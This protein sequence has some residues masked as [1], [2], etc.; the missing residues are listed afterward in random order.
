VDRPLRADAARNRAALLA[1]AE[2]AFAEHGVEASVADIA[3]RAGI[4]KGT[5]FRH[6]PTKDDLLAAVVMDRVTTL[7]ALASELS[8]RPDPGPALEEFLFAAAH[9][10]Q[11]LDLSFLREAPDVDDRLTDARRSLFEA[12]TVLVTRAQSAGAVRE[13][14]TGVDVILMMCA[15]HYVTTLVPSPSPDLWRRYLGIIIDGLR[16]QGA[17]PLPATGASPA[18]TRSSR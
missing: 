4:G 9:K 11:Q 13:D 6:F 18:P 7:S 10:Q 12:I 5:V 17:R 16:P 2:A 3:R 1:A 15:P 8:G 14:V